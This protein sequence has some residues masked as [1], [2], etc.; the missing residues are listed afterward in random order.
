MDST[1]IKRFLPLL[2]VIL[3]IASILRFT[4]LSVFPPSM[5][6]DE[7]ALGYSAISIAQTGMD[8]WGNKYPMV[9]KSF[10]DYKP[11]GFFYATALLYKVIGWNFALPRLTSAIAGVFIVL[12]G[13]LWL[14][15]L[16]KSNEVGLLGGLILA[17]SPWTVHLSRMALESNLAL[18]FFTMGLLFMSYARNSKLFLLL[19]GIFF[20]LST[21]TYHGYRYTVFIFLFSVI[22]GLIIFNLN[23][24]KKILPQIKTFSLLLLI[25]TLLSLPGFLSSGVSNRLDQTLTLTSDEAMLYYDDQENDC[26]ITYN[27]T[28]PS[29]VPLCKIAYNKVT[30][31]IMVGLDSYLMH[32][33]PDFLFFSGDTSVG[34]NPVESGQFYIILF[35][36]WMMGIFVLLKD[37][38]KHLVIIIGYLVALLPSALSGNPH[39]IRLTVVIPFVVVTILHGYVF[40]KKYFKDNVFYL[41]T[42][43]IALVCMTLIFTT[44]YTTNT[45]ASHEGAATYLSFAND[46][47]QLSY[48]YVQNGYTVYA[49][50]DLFPE[51]HMYYAYWNRIDPRIAQESFKKVYT[52]NSGFERPKQFGEHM[53]FETGNIGEL[54]CDKNYNQPTLFITNDPHKLIPVTQIKENTNTHTFAYV[55]DM[56]NIRSN[57]VEFMKLCN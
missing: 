18:A 31:P 51:P 25:S 35:P 39:A 45:F 48:K 30:K 17:I 6:Q 37:Y 41:P 16:F 54:T 10:G 56:H 28:I 53:F 3:F 22:L 26:H 46:I 7:V 4:Y 34:R 50:H 2:L 52:E 44:K 33:S 12:S 1:N 38:K 42:I 43:I 21:Y 27:Q 23:N 55:Y 13:S 8:E 32:L 40:F 19:S 11:P 14:R 9:F 29:L 47:S 15:K 24:I 57:K 20:S 5:V 49:D 36:F